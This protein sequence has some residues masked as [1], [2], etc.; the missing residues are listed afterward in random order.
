MLILMLQNVIQWYL[1]D[2]CHGRP[3][4]IYNKV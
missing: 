1:G 2:S 4:I 3:H